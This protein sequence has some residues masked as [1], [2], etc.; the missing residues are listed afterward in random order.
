MFSI[1]ARADVVFVHARDSDDAELLLRRLANRAAGDAVTAALER[2]TGDQQIGFVFGHALDQCFDHLI[3][4]LGKIIVAAINGRDDFAV[5]SERLLQR[6]AR[7]DGS[8]FECQADV[9]LCPR[10][11]SGRRT[12]S[13]NGRHGFFYSCD[14]PNLSL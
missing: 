14:I 1:Q 4:M 12:D 7:T 8:V 10:R 9:G 6:A 5:V 3:L 2:R 11:R 13:G